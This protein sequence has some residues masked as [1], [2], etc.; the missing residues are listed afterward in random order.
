MKLTIWG[1]FATTVLWANNRRANVLLYRRMFTYSSEA[2]D[3]ATRAVLPLVAVDQH[4]VVVR[5]WAQQKKNDGV[6]DR[7]HRHMP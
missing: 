2:A 1:H 3:E 5:I 7:V 6:G 4:R